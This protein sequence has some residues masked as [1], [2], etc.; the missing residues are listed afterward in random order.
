MI[1]LTYP[2][3][4]YAPEQAEEKPKFYQSRS[5]IMQDTPNAHTKYVQIS[6]MHIYIIYI[7]K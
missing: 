2:V 4:Q 1:K 7:C 3:H 6:I 5:I